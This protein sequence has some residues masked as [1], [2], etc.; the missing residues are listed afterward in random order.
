TGTS[1][2]VQG[3]ASSEEEATRIGD[4]IA[5][6]LPANYTLRRQISYLL[7]LPETKVELKEE[8]KPAPVPDPVPEVVLKE[9]FKPAPVKDAEPKA[10]EEESATV[11]AADAAPSSS[12]QQEA[13]AKEEEVAV[14]E[15]DFA[16]LFEG[17]N[18]LF[19]TAKADIKPAS[20]AL[21]DRIAD[22]LAQCANSKIEI[23]GH[24][25]SRGS[26]SYNQAL[27]EARA[28]S[29]LAYLAKKDGV[30]AQ[31]LAAK[32]YGETTPIVSNQG[33]ERSKNRRIEFKIIEN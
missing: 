21:L 5:G 14:C 20:F 25:D 16:A 3:R 10:V 26:A 27:S 15:V 13:P 8:F 32:G 17:E 23:G 6:S 24:T 2:F 31:N 11:A 22:G 18:I 30:N 29:V 9:E 28:Q 7:P 33:P 12:D 4:S 1:A 19:D